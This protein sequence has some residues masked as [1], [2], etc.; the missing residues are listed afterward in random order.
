VNGSRGAD[1]GIIE[2]NV[3]MQFNEERI[4]D[5]GYLKDLANGDTEFIKD[6]LRTFIE[7][8]PVYVSSLNE[9]LAKE[10]WP[11]VRAVAH[12]MSSPLGMLGISRLEEVIRKIEDYAHNRIRLEEVTELVGLTENVCRTVVRELEQELQNS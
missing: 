6:M 12:K 5:L 11:A 3:F 10:D 8:V 4:T 2:K 9:A 1:R 7:Q